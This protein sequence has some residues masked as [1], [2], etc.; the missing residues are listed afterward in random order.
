MDTILHITSGDIA[1]GAIEKSG[2]PGELFVWHD[3]LYDGPR[4]PG[5]PSDTMLNDRALFLEGVTGGG[6]E[7]EQ[8]LQTLRD[9]YRKIA[10]GA[11]YGQIV[12]WFDACLFDQSMLVHLLVL[13]HSLNIRKV[14]LLC[15]AA[16]P[17]IEPFDGL[18]QL[19]PAQLASL[20][21]QRREVTE[22]QFQFAQV[23][24]S[25]FARQDFFQLDEISEKSAA[26]LPWVPA[27]A[28]RWI[29]EQ[30]DP[31]TGLGRL[32]QLVLDA[33][34]NGCMTPWEIFSAVAANDRHPQYWGDITLWA[35]INGLADRDPPLVRIEGPLQRLPQWKSDVDWKQFTITG[36]PVS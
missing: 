29:Q 31:V 20:Y 25:A 16:F 1:G 32:E 22:A 3:I 28:A 36:L 15:V 7:K 10:A 8:V 27:A 17:G 14:E 5:W 30:P 9:Q 34:G 24:D 11:N 6:M 23:V 21:D 35:K 4:K 18:G 13:L 19:Q 33:I 12:L 2:L 26:P